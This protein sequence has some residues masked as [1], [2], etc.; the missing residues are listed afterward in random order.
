[1]ARL[2]LVLEVAAAII[3]FFPLALSLLAVA[4]RFDPSK[5][6]I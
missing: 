1:M 3:F 2:L 6:P 4:S 5:L